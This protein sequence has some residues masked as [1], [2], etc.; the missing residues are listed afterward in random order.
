MLRVAF[1]NPFTS[2]R[3]NIIA[4][5]HHIFGYSEIIGKITTTHIH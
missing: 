3:N 4:M 2:Y 5:K 1:A